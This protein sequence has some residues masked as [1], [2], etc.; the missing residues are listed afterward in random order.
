MSKFK[1]IL[2]VLALLVAVPSVPIKT[3]WAVSPPNIFI[4]NTQSDYAVGITGALYLPANDN[5]S[6]L[7]IQNK[8]LNGIYVKLGSVQVGL[9][10]L[11]VPAGGAYQYGY[12]VPKAA[13]YLV[14]GVGAAT[15]F[16]LE[17]VQP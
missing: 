5:R 7:F 13:V 9:E 14:T 6:F 10:G 2:W 12:P 15:G 8:S 16:L 4:V 11:L 3:A 1:L 17:G